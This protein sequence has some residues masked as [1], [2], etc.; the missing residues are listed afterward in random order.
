MAA[1]SRLSYFD[2]YRGF[3]ILLMVMGH[4]ALFGQRFDHYIHA[5]HM[6]LFFLVSGYFAKPEKERKFLPFVAHIAQTLLVP[7]LVFAIFLCQPLHYLYT[8]DFSLRYML[9]SLVSSNHNRI[10]VA[11]AYW[12]LLCLFSC[13][14]LFWGVMRFEHWWQRATIVAL[15]SL[16]GLLECFRLPLCLDSAMSMLGVMYIGYIVKSYQKNRGVAWMMNAPWW[17]A[18][19]MVLAGGVLVML[20]GPV[21]IRCN[22][23]ARIWLFLPGC[24]LTLFG[25]L[26]LARWLDSLKTRALRGIVWLLEYMGRNSIVFLVLNEVVIYASG[27]VLQWM[28]VSP[29][30]QRFG[31]GAPVQG[32]LNLVLTT[33]GLIVATEF[34]NRTWF[35]ICLGKSLRR[36]N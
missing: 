5:F 18:A 16:A 26:A 9:L 31:W 6:P 22:H 20:N 10:D 4:T 28:S 13:R 15:L 30:L 2:L 3:G 7:Y 14:V 11:G 8:H 12:F 19:S 17:C 33:C 21:I 1:P 24:L 27:L 36:V 25:Y 29:W 23:Y 32:M 34:F 35:R